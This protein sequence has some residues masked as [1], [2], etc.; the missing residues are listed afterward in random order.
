[1]KQSGHQMRVRFKPE[2]KKWIEKQA[3]EQDRS[4][5]WIINELVRKAMVEEKS[6]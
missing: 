5:N 4:Q 3:K 6:T 1:M 2:F